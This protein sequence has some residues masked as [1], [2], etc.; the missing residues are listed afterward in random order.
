MYEVTTQ[1]FNK[2]ILFYYFD[3]LYNYLK[4]LIYYSLEVK[5]LKIIHK[6]HQ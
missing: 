5:K 2:V 3:T 1:N 4:K 6:I